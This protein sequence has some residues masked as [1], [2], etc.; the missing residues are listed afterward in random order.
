MTVGSGPTTVIK[1]ES[2][3]PTGTGE[4]PVEEQEVT[5]LVA[6]RDVAPQADVDG[7]DVSPVLISLN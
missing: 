7:A 2:T 3:V 4:V 6:D 5:T 1:A